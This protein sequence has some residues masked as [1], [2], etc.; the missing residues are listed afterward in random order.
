MAVRGVPASAREQ[1]PAIL[2]SYFGRW[3]SAVRMT[4]IT[5]GDKGA[6]EREDF[7]YKMQY[8]LG[9]L[10]LAVNKEETFCLY[11]PIKHRIEIATPGKFRVYIYF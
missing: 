11:S 1:L 3:K 6:G 10:S 9:R 7:C 2:V 8:F 4:K 5:L